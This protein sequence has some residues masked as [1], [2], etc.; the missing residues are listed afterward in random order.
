MGKKKQTGPPKPPMETQAAAKRTRS[1]CSGEEC[2]TCSKSVNEEDVECQWCFN[3]EHKGCAGLTQ[4]EYNFLSKSP[5]KV[6][7]YCSL[8]HPKVSTA[9][10]YYTQNFDPQEQLDRITAIEEKLSKLSHQLN[11]LLPTEVPIVD[12]NGDVPTTQNASVWKVMPPG[13]LSIS[14]NV[15]S[16]IVA[17]QKEKERRQLNLQGVIV[18]NL[19]ESTESDAL[20]RK[21]KDIEEASK[22][23]TDYLCVKAVLTKVNRIGKQG[24]KPRLLKVSVDTLNNKV[25]I[26]RNKMNLRKDDN[27]NH[28]KAIY[29][30]AD[31]TPM[32][33]QKNKLLR[34]H[35]KQT[36][37]DGNRYVIK[38]GAIVQRRI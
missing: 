30:T 14:N 27:P 11:S 6:M 12:A 3:W 24:S 19:A 36:N 23:F 32:E 15:A 5:G 29:I 4:S 18:H 9:L 21:E 8:C 38:N 26:L 13:L 25:S 16:T 1:E 7:F 20:I 34:E 22:L 31:L 37:K 17:E 2:V 28:I 10:E 35:L 33:Q